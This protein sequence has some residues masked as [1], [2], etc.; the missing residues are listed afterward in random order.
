M[1][2]NLMGYLIGAVANIDVHA[3]LGA[4]PVRGPVPSFLDVNFVI[5]FLP[6][7]IRVCEKLTGLQTLRGRSTPPLAGRTCL[8][9]LAGCS[10]LLYLSFLE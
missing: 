8:E 2:A 4:V 3:F 6:P 9:A 10:C 7:H 1:T 5:F